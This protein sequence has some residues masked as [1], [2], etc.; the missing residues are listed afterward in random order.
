[1]EIAAEHVDERVM[2]SVTDR[3]PG[4]PPE[5]RDLIFERFTRLDDG[6]TVRGIGL[7]L[8]I[9][10]QLVARCRGLVSVGDAEG[11]GAVFRVSLP[12]AQA[13]PDP[14]PPHPEAAHSAS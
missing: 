13:A 10:R 8:P 4:V 5:Q 14:E 9:V 7:G 3:G 12:L 2:L 1:V 6:E 11:G